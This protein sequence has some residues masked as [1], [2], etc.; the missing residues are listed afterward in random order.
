ML[1]DRLWC[2]LFILLCCGCLSMWIKAEEYEVN[3]VDTFDNEIKQDQHDGDIPETPCQAAELLRW[4]KLFVALE[5][6]YMRQMM[7]MEAL[8]QR[9]EAPVVCQ[10][11]VP[12]ID[13]VCRGQ[14]EQASARLQRGLLELKEE[15]IQRERRMN[16]SLHLI[17]Q[18]GVGHYRQ[19]MAVL[20]QLIQNSSEHS[21]RLQHLEAGRLRE[22]KERVGPVGSG[23]REGEPIRMGT[24]PTQLIGAE[25]GEDTV[26]LEVGFSETDT[27]NRRRRGSGRVGLRVGSGMKTFSSRNRK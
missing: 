7:L 2:G 4:D 8:K 10:Q 19:M 15:A 3:Y 21:T 12:A 1:L 11:C 27:P 6:S 16:A 9:C 26:G 22:E 23:H 25:Y 18:D 5:D 14:A 24:E 20:Q 17:K 13:A